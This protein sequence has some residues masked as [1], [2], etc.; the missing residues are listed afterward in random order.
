MKN[1]DR[2]ERERTADELSE[3]REWI[4]KGKDD[5]WHWQ[6][7][8]YQE[9]ALEENYNTF[10]AYVDYWE[11]HKIAIT[12]DVIA[13]FCGSEMYEIWIGFPDD[14]EEKRCNHCKALYDYI[15]SKLENEQP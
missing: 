15:N 12:D 2:F 13:R 3:A 9:Q 14:N 10:K 8:I 5:E 4:A 1:Q 7:A 6:N 11:R